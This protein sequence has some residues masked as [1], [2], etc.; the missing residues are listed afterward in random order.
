MVAPRQLRERRKRSRHA[1]AGVNGGHPGDPYGGALV[2]EDL[3]RSRKE[4]RGGLGDGR[5]TDRCARGK[6]CLTAVFL[7]LEIFPLDV[8]LA[9]TKP[10]GS[11]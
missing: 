4:R 7:F 11:I 1:H 3:G 10:L 2:A 5:I 6:P 8:L 9:Y